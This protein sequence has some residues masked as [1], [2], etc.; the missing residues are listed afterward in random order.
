MIL[1]ILGFS[2]FNS[3]CL[4]HRCICQ[5][6][7]VFSKEKKTK[8]HLV[9]LNEP[10]LYHIGLQIDKLG[11]VCMRKKRVIVEN[12]PSG[13]WMTVTVPI[14]LSLPASTFSQRDSAVPSMKGGTYFPA[15]QGWV[16]SHGLFGPLRGS[17]RTCSKQGFEKGFALVY[18]LVSA[19]HLVNVSRL[20][21]WSTEDTWPSCRHLLSPRPADPQT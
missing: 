14:S 2:I 21:C 11:I 15:P 1:W 17:Q 20:T 3:L 8:S 19:P 5:Y 12:F 10:V 4:H 13:T 7:S 16:Q 9:F 6:W 18:C